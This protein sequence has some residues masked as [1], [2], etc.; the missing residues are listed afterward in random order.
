[1]CGIVGIASKNNCISDIISGL[2]S[3]EYRGYDSAG[4]ATVNND[5]FEF[6]KNVG[7]ISDLEKEVFKHDLKGNVAIG[8]TRWATHGKPSLINSHPFIKDNY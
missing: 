4:L 7:K 8:H 1:M 2:H 3:L 5:R 6:K